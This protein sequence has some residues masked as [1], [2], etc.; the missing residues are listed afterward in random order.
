MA[1]MVELDP[2]ELLTNYWGASHPLGEWL[3]AAGFNKVYARYG[4]WCV[5][6]YGLESLT[7]PGG[8]GIAKGRLWEGQGYHDWVDHMSEKRWVN[9][10]DFAMALLAAQECHKKET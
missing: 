4:D 1:T 10:R 2:N 9:I 5:T 3:K 7:Y 8:Y 6:D